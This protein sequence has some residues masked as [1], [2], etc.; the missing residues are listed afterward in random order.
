MNF[1]FHAHS[2]LRYLVLLAAVAALVALAYALT[3]AR[4]VRA[5]RILPAAFTGL[6]DIQILLGAGLVMG[7]RFPDAVV[8]HL[9]LMVLAAVVAHGSSILAKR[10]RDDRR[11][12]GI[13]LAGIVIALALIVAGILAIGR[14]VLGT[15]PPTVH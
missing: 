10:S 8:G 13:R 15:A 11:E 7:G 2:G 6:L 5:A 12:L 4:P 3:T 9:V 14:G 1:L